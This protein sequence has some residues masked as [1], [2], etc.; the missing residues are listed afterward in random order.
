M[1]ENLI[2]KIMNLIALLLALIL[3]LVTAGLLGAAAISVLSALIGN[4]P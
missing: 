1:L 3:L 4:L 2:V